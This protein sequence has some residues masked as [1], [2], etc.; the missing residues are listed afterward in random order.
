MSRQDAKIIL[1]NDEELLEELRSTTEKL[2]A[3]GYV[4]YIP[5]VRGQ[6]YNSDALR[7]VVAAVQ[8]VSKWWVGAEQDLGGD[9][10]RVSFPRIPVI[11]SL[12]FFHIELRGDGISGSDLAAYLTLPT[13]VVDAQA[14]VLGGDLGFSPAPTSLL[15]FYLKDD[16]WYEF[17]RIKLS[18]MNPVDQARIID[19]LNM[20]GV[21]ERFSAIALD[22]HQWGAAVLQRLH[23]SAF[24]PLKDYRT[25]VFDVGFATRIQG[26]IPAKQYY[27]DLLKKSLAT[28]NL[29][30]DACVRESIH[31]YIF[32][33]RL[34]DVEISMKTYG[35]AIDVDIAGKRDV[36]RFA[37]AEPMEDVEI[38]VPWDSRL[39]RSLYGVIETGE[40]L[41]RGL[42]E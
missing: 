16:G 15:I 4:R 10:I 35:V 13:L 22:A 3:A 21:P 37:T 32:G 39:S 14:W 2:T 7:C 36:F 29:W 41:V 38:S 42:C 12:P 8:R 26:R 24:H 9:G 40:S 27:T 17:A 20:Y 6:D 34:G 19:Y 31:P 1:A 18:H 25:K 33:V 28:G 11:P 23:S 5:A 30:L